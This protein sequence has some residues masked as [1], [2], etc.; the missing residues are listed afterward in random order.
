MLKIGLLGAGMMGN[1][2]IGGVRANKAENVKYI[3]VFDVDEEKRN[4]FAE[5]YEIK[6]YGSL[7]E[8]LADS[9]VDIVDLSL[10]SHMH[11]RFCIKIAEAGKHVFVEKPIAFELKAAKRML[12]A[13]KRNGVRLMVGQVIRFWP[14]YAKIKEMYDEGVF[15][16]LK[17][18]YCARLGQMPTWGEWY[19]DPEKSGET[20]MNLTLHDIDFLHY[21][22]GKPKSVYSAGLK[23]DLD[24]YN[25]VMNILTFENGTNAIVDGSLSMTPGYPFTMHFR[26]SGTKATVEFLYKAGENIRAGATISFKLYVEGEEPKDIEF[27]D[28]DGYGREIEYFAQ[29]IENKTETEWVT[30]QSVLTVLSSVIAAKESLG[31]NKVK[32]L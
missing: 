20:L 2:H 31:D 24:N 13:A 7:E 23:D 1:T 25:D 29:C 9:E 15:G 14:Q 30:N 8:M 27:E 10:P 19:K 21:L 5:K 3:G 18:V 28:Y 16:E 17:G 26:G 11:E 4:T 22:I 6:S 12:D 32:K